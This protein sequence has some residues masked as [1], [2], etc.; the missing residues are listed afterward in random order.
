MKKQKTKQVTSC[1]K[2]LTG[3][4]LWRDGDIGEPLRVFGITFINILVKVIMKVK[5]CQACGMMYE[6]KLKD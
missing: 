6:E 5:V 1:P 4:H 2:S 3:E